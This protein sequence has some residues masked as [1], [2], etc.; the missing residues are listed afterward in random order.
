MNQQPSIPAARGNRIAYAMLVYLAVFLCLSCGVLLIAGRQTLP[1]LLFPAYFMA[2]LLL[3]TIVNRTIPLRWVLFCFI[4]GAT[5]VPL[6]TL[7][8]SKPFGNLLDVDSDIFAS[9]IVPI[10]EE[11]IKTVPLLMLLVFPWWRYRRTAGA[12]DLLI[13]GAA[14]GAG[15]AFYED[16][17]RGFLPGFSPDRILAMHTGTPHLGPLYFFPNMDVDVRAGTGW[18]LHT[19]DSNVAFIGHGGATAFIGLAIGL[20]RLLGARLRGLIGGFRRIVWIIPL[21]AWGWMVFDHAM[22]NY[23]EDLDSLHLLLKIP[24]TLDGYGYLSSV[25][26]YLL[27][28]VTIG[29]E[30]WLLWQGRQRT[31]S[32]RLSM[33]R[34]K[35]LKGALERPLEIAPHLLNL[36]ALLR[37]R[38]GLSYGLYYYHQA[39]KRDTAQRDYL[40]QLAWALLLLKRSLELS[41][42]DSVRGPVPAE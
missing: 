9:V 14:L 17:L 11:T 38:R 39:G 16:T 25:A 24:Y 41:P 12:T 31:V 3:L 35:V 29:I 7:L 15:F 2:L 40:R 36:R 20:A 32:L 4:L 6:L 8:F 19:L 33:D 23:A 27:I 37:E 22:F 18:L 34:L 28:L 30:R 13:L 1:A 42:G 5:A 10:L 26:L 21:V